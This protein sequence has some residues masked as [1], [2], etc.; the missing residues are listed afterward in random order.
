M[1]I[2]HTDNEYL[3]KCNFSLD[4]FT[5]S[6]AASILLWL[7]NDHISLNFSEKAASLKKCYSVI[8]I[9]LHIH[10]EIFRMEK[11]F[12]YKLI[13]TYTHMHTSHLDIQSLIN[14]VCMKK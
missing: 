1:G 4:H 3:E 14:K 8:I 9:F 2:E 7:T 5:S 6:H 12:H 13:I 11:Y 10:S